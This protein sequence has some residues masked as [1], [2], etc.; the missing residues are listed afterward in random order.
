MKPPCKRHELAG[1]LDECFCPEPV[2]PGEAEVKWSYTSAW[3]ASVATCTVTLQGRTEVWKA[4]GMYITD[5]ERIDV[6]KLLTDRIKT[7][8]RLFGP[9]LEDDDG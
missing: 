6:P 7:T 4:K 5:D 9:V 8:I 2:G 3:G 1:L